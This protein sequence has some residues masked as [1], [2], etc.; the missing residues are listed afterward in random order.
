MFCWR[1]AVLKRTQKT[2]ENIF[3]VL[4]RELETENWKRKALS[5]GFGESDSTFHD[6]KKKKKWLHCSFVLTHVFT[7]ILTTDPSFNSETNNCNLRNRMH[8]KQ[9]WRRLLVKSEFKWK[10]KQ[11]ATTCEVQ[12]H[13]GRVSRLHQP[14]VTSRRSLHVSRDWTEGRQLN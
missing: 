3:S 2:T 12:V 13:P 9:P 14:P 5:L 4:I 7:D 6:V 10:N 1:S 8:L 11:S